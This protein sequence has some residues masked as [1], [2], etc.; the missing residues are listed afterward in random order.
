LGPQTLKNIDRPI[1]VY[2]LESK[3][4]LIPTAET[5][6]SRRDWGFPFVLICDCLL[7]AA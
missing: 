4:G 7:R 1:Q 3:D 2:R 6:D 5:P